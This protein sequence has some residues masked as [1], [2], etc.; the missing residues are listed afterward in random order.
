[1]LRSMEGYSRLPNL[2]L[3]TTAA[4]VPAPAAMHIKTFVS[5]LEAPTAASAFWLTNL[6]TI[7]ES[8]IL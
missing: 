2:L 7:A 6:P 5:A 1:M 3:T 8:A 4:P